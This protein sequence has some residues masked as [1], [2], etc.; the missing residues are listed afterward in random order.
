MRKPGFKKNYSH[1]KKKKY[2][3]SLLPKVKLSSKA[4]TFLRGGWGGRFLHRDSL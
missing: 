3:L 1:E 4:T 2:S